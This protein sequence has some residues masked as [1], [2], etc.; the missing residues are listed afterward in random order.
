MITIHWD[1][2]TDLTVEKVRIKRGVAKWAQFF[3]IDEISAFNPNET[4]RTQYE[5]IDGEEGHYYKISFVNVTGNESVESDPVL[6]QRNGHTSFITQIGNKN[7]QD[8]DSSDDNVWVQYPLR[9]YHRY[10]P[11]DVLLTGDA[12]PYSKTPTDKICLSVSNPTF[13]ISLLPVKSNITSFKL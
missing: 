1:A 6:G 9:G 13:L 3:L 2:P 11:R 8:F 4:W 7:I 12:S 5:D 10:T